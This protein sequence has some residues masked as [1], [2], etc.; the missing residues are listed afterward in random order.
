MAGLPV[1]QQSTA[2]YEN[3]TVGMNGFPETE[4]SAKPIDMQ[5]Q[6]KIM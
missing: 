1:Q 2:I 5:L 6:I 3:K 4:A